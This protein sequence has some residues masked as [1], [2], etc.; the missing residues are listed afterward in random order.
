M[1]GSDAS[2]T[3][4]G[5]SVLILY[6]ES[7]LGQLIAAAVAEALVMCLCFSRLLSLEQTLITALIRKVPL[8]C[9]NPLSG[10][11]MRVSG[12]S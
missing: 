11:L 12:I 2:R 1:R 9:R 10:S 8:E 5:H 7:W 6:Q 3:A 4:F